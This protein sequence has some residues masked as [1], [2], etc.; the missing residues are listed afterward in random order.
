MTSVLKAVADPKRTESLW[1]N[2][3]IV[4][5]CVEGN[6]EAWDAFL[7]KYK[8]LIFSIPIK[9]GFSPED[10]ADIFQA[11]CLDAIAELS[12]LR[13]PD[14]LPKWLMEVTSHKCF[15]WKRRESRYVSSDADGNQ[16]PPASPESDTEEILAQTQQEQ[17]LR[18]AVASLPDRCQQLVRMLFFESTHRPYDEVA[19]SLGLA[20]GSIGFIRRRCLDKLRRRLQELN[21]R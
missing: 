15:H 3:R 2:A 4:R 21:F 12:K 8:N 16:E 5:G 18:E 11:V 14:A 1:T 7:D 6:E 9:Y 10:A 20:T 13:E 19:R 17:V